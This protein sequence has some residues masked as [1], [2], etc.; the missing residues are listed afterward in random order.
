MNA[1]PMYANCTRYSGRTSTFAP[2][3]SSSTG[4]PGSGTSTAIAGLCTPLIRLTWNSDAASSA[5]VD[6]AET[7]AS[8]SPP[9]TAFAARTIEASSFERTANAGSSSFVI[10][11]PPNSST[12]MPARRAPS[13]TRSG[14]PS[15]PCTSTATGFGLVVVVVVMVVLRLGR[16]HLTTGVRPAV[17]ADAMRQPRLAALRAS[18]HAG[19]R[20]LVLRAALIRARM[21]LSL[22]WDGHGTRQSSYA[23]YTA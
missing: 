22:L 18:T 21:G 1:A 15:A 7:S 11:T 10:S 5:P 23:E 9:P 19:R 2:A 14:P 16:E 4:L 3:S 17:Q 6:P 20:D 12:G 8:A 13:A